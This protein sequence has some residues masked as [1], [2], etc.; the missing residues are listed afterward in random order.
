MII[1]E[2]WNE[3]KQIEI[4]DKHLK[5]NNTDDPNDCGS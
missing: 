4:K 5:R 1:E 3:I 2:F